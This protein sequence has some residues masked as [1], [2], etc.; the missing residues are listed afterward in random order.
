MTPFL[1]IPVLIKFSLVGTFVH[2][3]TLD[4]IITANKILII[5]YSDAY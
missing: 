4:V 5:A 1:L 3:A 2:V